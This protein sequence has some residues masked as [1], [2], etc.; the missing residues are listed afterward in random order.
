MKTFQVERSLSTRAKI[1]AYDKG[2]LFFQNKNFVRTLDVSS[3]TFLHDIRFEPHQLDSIICSANSN[4]VVILS[5][6]YYYSKLNVYDL[7]C[8]KETDAIPSHL[9]LTSI[10]L[11]GKV[12]KVMMN[13]TRMVCL[14]NHIMYVVDL[15]PFDRLRCP[16]YTE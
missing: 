6:N 7:K 4:Y 2:C 13:E 8:L 12:K 9:L 10:D 16:E 5:Y 14:E 3:G 11:E 15:K 1:F